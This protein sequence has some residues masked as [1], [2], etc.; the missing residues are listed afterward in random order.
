MKFQDSFYMLP[1]QHIWLWK[2]LWW[3]SR[4]GL[5]WF[6]VTVFSASIKDVW[7]TIQKLKAFCPFWC[8]GAFHQCRRCVFQYKRSWNGAQVGELKGEIDKSP[9][10]PSTPPTS[11]FNLFQS[12]RTT[13]I[14]YENYDFLDYCG[15]WRFRLVAGDILINRIQKSEF[16]QNGPN[17]ARHKLK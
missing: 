1:W 7:T 16:R 4:F 5:Y 17:C 8:Q 3:L 14:G 6:L 10:P 12:G 13:H 15:C 2:E 11:S 9:A